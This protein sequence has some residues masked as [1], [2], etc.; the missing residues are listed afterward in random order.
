[1]PIE[2]EHK[3]L[4]VLKK[5]ILD[6]NDV[7]NARLSQLYQVVEFRLGSYENSTIYMK[8]MKIF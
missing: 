7:A 6:W 5:L 1:M 3:V 8:R 4:W 2:L